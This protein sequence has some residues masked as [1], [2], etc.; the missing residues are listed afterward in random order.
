MIFGKPQ[1]AEPEPGPDGIIEGN[2]DDQQG[3][4]NEGGSTA[5]TAVEALVDKA[6]QAYDN[7]VKAQ[8]SGDWAKYGEYMKELEA[9]LKELKEA[10]AEPTGSTQAPKTDE[11]PGPTADQTDTGTDVPTEDQGNPDGSTAPT[12]QPAN[13]N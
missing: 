9:I 10:S 2:T 7:A 3:S 5:S 4:G 11:A 1:Q 8:Q 13:Q 12:D 6:Q